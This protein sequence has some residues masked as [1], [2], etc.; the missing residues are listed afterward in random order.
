[1]SRIGMYTSEEGSVY[2]ALLV[3]YVGASEVP[4]F[5]T[6]GSIKATSDASFDVVGSLKISP[7]MKSTMVSVF[8]VSI[9]NS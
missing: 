5:V 6:S 2:K 4:P 1:M 8:T 7:C 3:E 9:V